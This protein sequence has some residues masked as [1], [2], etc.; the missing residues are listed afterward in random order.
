MSDHKK[1]MQDQTSESQPSEESTGPADEAT[2]ANCGHHIEPDDIE[3]PSCGI[4]L[5]AG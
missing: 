1:D 4:S 2:C 3:C 5:V